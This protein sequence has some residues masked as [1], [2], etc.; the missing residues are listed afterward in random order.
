MAYVGETRKLS[1][2][3]IRKQQVNRDQKSRET[4]EPTES[5]SKTASS[6]LQNTVSSLGDSG[7]R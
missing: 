5:P 1:M 3:E 6:F 2:C 7:E 4:A